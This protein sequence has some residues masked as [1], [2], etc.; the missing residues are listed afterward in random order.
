MNLG[1][2]LFGEE[3]QGAV[4]WRDGVTDE[5]ILDHWVRLQ[6]LPRQAA[7]KLKLAMA[8]TISWAELSRALLPLCDQ[9][10]LVVSEDAMEKE[11]GQPLYWCQ[12]LGWTNREQATQYDGYMQQEGHLPPGGKWSYL[13]DKA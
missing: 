3:I 2:I 13:G 10:W 6:G 12:E 4:E 5:E 7:D 1:I 11:T 8:P 9:R